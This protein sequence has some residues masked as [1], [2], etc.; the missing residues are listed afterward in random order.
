VGWTE[1]TGT[2]AAVGPAVPASDDDKEVRVQQ[3]VDR[4][5]AGKT[6]VLGENPP[7]CHSGKV[8]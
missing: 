4:E 5:F 3:L 7:L 6:E 2:S 1:P 8:R